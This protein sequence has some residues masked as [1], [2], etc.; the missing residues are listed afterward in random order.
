MKKAKPRPRRSPIRKDLR[1]AKYRPRV[2]RSKRVYNRKGAP[3]PIDYEKR[4]MTNEEMVR[5]MLWA[6]FGQSEC[7]PL[8]RH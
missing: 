4:I 8:T 5:F 2:V 1:T 7:Q 3:L 6:L